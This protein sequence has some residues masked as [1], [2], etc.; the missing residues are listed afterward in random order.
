MNSFWVIMGF[1]GL[2]MFLV[3]NTAKWPPKAWWASIKKNIKTD[4]KIYLASVFLQVVI[5]AG[6]YQTGFDDFI[7]YVAQFFGQTYDQHFFPMGQLNFL[8]PLIGLAIHPLINTGYKRYI[9][10]HEVSNEI[11]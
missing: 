11:H 5:S 2:I 6:W 7:A 8:L 3:L 1:V 10:P 9:K 4:I